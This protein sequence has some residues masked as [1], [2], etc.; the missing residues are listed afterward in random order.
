M[1]KLQL[2]SGALGLFLIIVLISSC[3]GTK[4]EDSAYKLSQNPPFTIKEVYSQKWM[5][6]VQEGGSG[7]NIY[8]T[9]ENIELGT[10]IKE[11]YFRNKIVNL[12]K[13]RERLFIGYFKNKQ[14][15]I[16]MNSDSTKEANNIPPQK[17]PFQL[18]T[19]EA[20]L[21]YIYKG[22]DYYFKVSNI[23]EKEVIA[24]PQSNPNNSN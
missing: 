10:I 2:V 5:A 7:I 12:E 1:K 8:F 23:T 17:F 9:I 3:G 4:T 15:D 20:V 22:V 24:Y 19:N 11:V 14:K 18:E 21:S 6:G 16:I 13:K